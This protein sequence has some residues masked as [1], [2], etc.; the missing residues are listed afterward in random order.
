MRRRFILP[1][2]FASLAALAVAIA[3]AFES[4]RSSEVMLASVPESVESGATLP[5]VVEVVRDTDDVGGGAIVP[6]RIDAMLVDEHGRA[7]VRSQLAPGLDGRSRGVLS[8]PMDARGVSS[9]ELRASGL[10]DAPWLRARIRVGP[11]AAVVSPT[12]RA[13]VIGVSP[14]S[15]TLLVRAEG[16]ACAPGLPCRVYV[17]EPPGSEHATYEAGE[18]T[19][20]LGTTR[21]DRR[22]R[23]DV[24]IDG[25][26]GR[27]SARFPEAPAAIE[28]GVPVQLGCARF[29][30]ERAY[31]HAGQVVL[32]LERPLSPPTVQIDRY[33]G[34]RWLET[35]VFAYE[36]L[37]RSAA[38][39]TVLG[40]GT[41]RFEAR[42]ASG[43]YLASALVVVEAQGAAPPWANRTRNDDWLADDPWIARRSALVLTDESLDDETRAASSL[44]LLVGSLERPT[45]LDSRVQRSMG[46]TDGPSPATLGLAAFVMLLG[47]LAAR[48]V[49]REG[50]FA[51]R[52]A[53]A[54]IDDAERPPSRR[55]DLGVLLPWT[56]L[57]A[58]SAAAAMVLYRG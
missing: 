28:L 33:V 5:V 6:T 22:V 56:I 30:A 17:S 15:E 50:R 10:P 58:F 49:A 1:V 8:L 7:V 23:L 27:L 53:D 48:Y 16:G 4:S 43:A 44:G 31:A 40:R 26:G 35:Q 9:L 18:G 54:L 42:D 25:F 2:A 36:D 19:V 13:R 11:G 24:R 12:R 32:R 14:T 21:E 39:P 34:G 52:Q 3:P 29:V 37:A 45:Q 41:H 55:T 57:L 46:A 38:W 51:Q 20:L 47:V